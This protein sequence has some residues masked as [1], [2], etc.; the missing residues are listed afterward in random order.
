MGKEEK[1]VIKYGL[2]TTAGLIAFFL[3]MKILGL[4]EVTELRT[5]NAVIM[6]SGVFLS[7]KRFRHRTFKLEFNYLTGI[8]AGFFTGLVTAASFALF[9]GI[10][11]YFD[12]IF[13]A[14]I[15]ADNPQKEFLNPLTA[16]MV[17]FIEAMA[18]GFL[19]SYI[20]M[21]YLKN[22]VTIPLSKA[23]EA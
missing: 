22:D 17:L 10:Y 8:A 3:L 7:I 2:T 12:P 21:Q 6:F 13:L 9:V 19:F 15:V 4:A 16:G 18:S 11:I 20:S 1:H 23:A 5:L 14:A